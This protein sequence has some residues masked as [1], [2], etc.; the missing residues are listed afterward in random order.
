METERFAVL[1]EKFDE[2]F[3][4][5]RNRRLPPPGFTKKDE[6]SKPPEIEFDVGA[7]VEALSQSGSWDDRWL[8]T[9]GYKLV[10][11]KMLYG[12]LKTTNDYFYLGTT[13]IVGNGEFHKLNPATLSLLREDHYRVYLVAALTEA[14]LDFMF[15]LLKGRQKDFKKNKWQSIIDAL[16]PEIDGLLSPDAQQRLLAFKDKYRTAELHKGSC[17]RGF[18]NKDQWNHFKQEEWDLG[19]ALRRLHAS[20]VT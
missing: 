10:D 6:G 17:V 14:L 16:K 20:M 2:Y 7:A 3:L 9:L 4:T 13:L 15:M 12:F 18:I 19:D 8:S 11:I 1:N 5:I